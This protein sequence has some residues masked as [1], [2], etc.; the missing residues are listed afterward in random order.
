MEVQYFMY[1]IIVNVILPPE[2][3]CNYYGRCRQLSFYTHLLVYQFQDTFN[4][5]NGYMHS[6][7]NLELRYML[8]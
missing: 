4:F 3:H 2:S 6:L 8:E 7:T 1:G 5:I